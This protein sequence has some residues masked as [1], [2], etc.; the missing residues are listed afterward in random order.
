MKHRTLQ[1]ITAMAVFLF[2]TTN[3]CFA[4]EKPIFEST[5]IAYTD[6]I[7]MF[8]CDGS[9]IY[10][11]K[12]M[13]VTGPKPHLFI[14]KKNMKTMEAVYSKELSEYHQFQEM[15]RRTN[16]FV[17]C[18]LVNDK[19]FTFYQYIDN[20]KDTMYVMLQTVSSSGD[21]SAVYNVLKVY[22]R[23][24]WANS[25]VEFS[26]DKES[27]MVYPDPFSVFISIN[28]AD[29]FFIDVCPKLYKSST[30]ELIWEKK[31]NQ[32][33]NNDISRIRSLKVDNRNNLYALFDEDLTTVLNVFE[34]NSP[35]AKKFPEF[36]SADLRCKS[37]SLKINK[38]GDLVFSGIIAD[39]NMDTRGF[40]GDPTLFLRVISTENLSV[41]INK[42][43]QFNSEVMNKLSSGLSA[44]K[45]NADQK[46]MGIVPTNEFTAPVICEYDG[47]Y[48]FVTENVFYDAYATK[49][50]F[51]D[52]VTAMVSADGALK[53]M[54]VIPKLNLDSWGQSVKPEVF[55]TNQKLVV[56][57]AE[58]TELAS[59]KFD[60]YESVTM[61]STKGHLGN[62]VIATSADNGTF[63]K[64]VL[65][66]NIEKSAIYRNAYG[67][68]DYFYENNKVVFTMEDTK[69]NTIKYVAYKID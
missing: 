40:Y 64:K 67:V 18:Y 2:F 39:K 24:T 17:K 35:T 1:L 4:Q 3:S 26:Q 22:T 6:P 45:P 12:M 63:S 43:Y 55:V 50:Y 69:A 15:V 16:P 66:E 37:A 52:I 8:A 56:L 11:S 31:L 59:K 30:L 49:R 54:N 46:K 38:A 20:E 28:P 47:G 58:N 23:N 53:F 62:I 25:V 61:P 29:K 33:V 42:D 34:P 57:F 36:L 51:K 13:K 27:F 14:E 48:Y 19:V 68:K 65:F 9:N 5:T 7:E 44:K 32:F 60:E 21:V 41:K 10:Y